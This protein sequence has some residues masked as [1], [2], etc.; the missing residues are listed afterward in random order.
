M[1]DDLVCKVKLMIW[2][3]NRSLSNL[4]SGWKLTLSISSSMLMMINAICFS[5]CE[6]CLFETWNVRRTRRNMGKFSS[7]VSNRLFSRY[8]KQ[9]QTQWAYYIDI[10]LAI[11][12]LIIIRFELC[13]L[14]FKKLQKQKFADFKLPIFLKSE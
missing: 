14:T 12:S 11:K 3:T 7:Y 2:S 5:S 9:T 10:Y 8:E 13:K 6:T 4:Y 1:I